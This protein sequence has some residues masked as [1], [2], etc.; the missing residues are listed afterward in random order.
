MRKL[1]LILLI[2]CAVLVGIV[3]LLFGSGELHRYR[4]PTGA[5]RPALV[6][7][8]QFVME[9]LSYRF[10]QPRR[11]DIIVF[12][13]AGIASIP[14]NDAWE[15][16]VVYVMRVVGLP[17]DTIQ[18]LGQ[19]LLVNGQDD[20]ALHSIHPQFSPHAIYLSN[21]GSSVRVPENAYFVMGDNTTKS[22]DSRFWGFV[23][24]KNI[25]GRAA[26]RYWPVTRAGLL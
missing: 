2:G 20:P 14:H 26:F 15:A 21:A 23:P 9:R 4:V 7:G 11:G 25:R 18:F 13:T 10:H 1:H 24:A 17:N 6:P 3:V 19:T 5:M 22:F 12:R 8:D 16:N